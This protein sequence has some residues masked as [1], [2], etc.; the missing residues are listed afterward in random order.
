MGRPPGKS[1]RRLGTEL[2]LA[3]PSAYG[4]LRRN[5][6]RFGFIQRYSWEPWHYES[7]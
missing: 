7:E 4:W 2:D 1:L 3:P 6:G 5:A